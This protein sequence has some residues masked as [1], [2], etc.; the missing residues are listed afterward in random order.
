MA[1]SF[2]ASDLEL[3]CLYR[4]A[5]PNILGYYGNSV[6][7]MNEANSTMVADANHVHV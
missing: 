2:A 5:C 6:I 1:S 7:L 3:H 4:S